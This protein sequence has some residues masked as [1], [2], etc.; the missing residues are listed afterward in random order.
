MATPETHAD[1]TP[2]ETY[3]D[4]RLKDQEKGALN[5]AVEGNTA[6]RVVEKVRFQGE[7]LFVVYFSART[8]A[9]TY[10]VFRRIRK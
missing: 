7:L 6:G 3:D 1:G 4:I 5:C 9:E 2:I 10:E 8:G